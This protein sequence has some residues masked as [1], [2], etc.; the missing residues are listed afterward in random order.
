[1]STYCVVFRAPE[2]SGAVRFY[3]KA[4]SADSAFAMAVEENPELRPL[5]VEPAYRALS[6]Q[7]HLN[8]A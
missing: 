6:I 8:A 5:G 3:L 2:V 4:D 1:M 7:D